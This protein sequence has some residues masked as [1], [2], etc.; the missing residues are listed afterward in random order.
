LGSVGF[1]DSAPTSALMLS[2]MDTAALGT[3]TPNYTSGLTSPVGVPSSGALEM[4]LYFSANG[5]GSVTSYTSGASVTGA[6]NTT[7]TLGTFNNG[8][9]GGAVT[10]TL[11]TPNSLSGASF[12]VT[13]TGYGATT[14]PTTATVTSGTASCSGT[15]VVFVTV[16][17]G[18]QG[19]AIAVTSARTAQ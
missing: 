19:T 1:T 11:T 4:G 14:A 9:T 3:S 5:L 13:N 16:L 8:L 18:A 10:A 6:I 17:G 7:C 2:T 15:G 12:A